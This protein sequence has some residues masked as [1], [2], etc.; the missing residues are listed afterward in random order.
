MGRLKKQQII[1]GK[2]NGFYNGIQKSL[3]TIDKSV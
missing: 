2:R 1:S 3:K